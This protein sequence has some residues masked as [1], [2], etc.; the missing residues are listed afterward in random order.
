[1]TKLDKLEKITNEIEHQTTL[2]KEIVTQ[3]EEITNKLKEL[4]EEFFTLS[5][6]WV[7]IKCPVC[8]GVGFKKSETGSKQKCDYCG[9]PD[10][11]YIWA[12][13]YRD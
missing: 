8:N 11:P 5:D 7:R 6:D 12:E 1:M 4:E 10:K 13:A 9:G 2:L 3:E